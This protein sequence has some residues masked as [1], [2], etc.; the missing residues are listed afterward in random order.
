MTVLAAIYLAV[1][2]PAAMAAGAVIAWRTLR[3]MHREDMEAA[4][5]A[6]SETRV[7]REVNRRVVDRLVELDADGTRRLLE[8][9]LPPSTGR[10]AREETS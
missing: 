2:L 9:A 6:V 1:V 7:L 3:S 5:A 8:Q 10:R 4:R